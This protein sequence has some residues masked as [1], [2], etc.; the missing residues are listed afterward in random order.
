MSRTRDFDDTYTKLDINLTYRGITV[1]S[2]SWK[3][4]LEYSSIRE[5]NS[6]SVY[7]YE[8]VDNTKRPKISLAID[9]EGVPAGEIAIWNIR[10]KDK[11]CMISYWIDSSLRRKKIATCAVALV[12][13]YCFIELDIEEVEAPVL[14]DNKASKELLTKLSYNI[15]GYETF[16]GKDGIQ[17][18]HET[19][20]LVKPENGIVYSLVDF[21][22]MMAQPPAE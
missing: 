7:P 8:I 22:E 16:T 5:R 1:R 13:D 15:S 18:A 2:I 4:S 3:E 12:T 10:E 21:L 11:A 17:R 6:D 14:P 19:Y 9:Y 20:L